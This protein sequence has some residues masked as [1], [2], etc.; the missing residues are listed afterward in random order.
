MDTGT[1]WQFDEFRPPGRDYGR[2][3]EV[4]I[5]DASHRDFRDLESEAA[6]ALDLIGL[7]GTE[8]LLDV[9]C[10]TGVFALAATQRCAAVQAAD[11]S[12]AMLEAA[13]QRA[14][15]ED[16]HNIQFHHAGFLTLALPERSLDVVTTTFAFHHLPDF[17]KGIALDNMARFL[18]PGGKLYMRDVILQSGQVLENIQTFIEHQAR[19]GGDF[20][21]E[22]AEGHFR[23]EYS[24]YDWVMDG[25]FTR[26]GFT[27]RHRSYEGGVIG[28]YV[29]TRD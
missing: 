15:A 19:L 3:E 12:E 8:M 6:G 13:R 23:D 4:A 29:L 25:L 27:I 5:Y 14:T 26:S 2:E 9:G 17:W 18:K 11:V 20:L 1:S 10:G 16:V 22:D 28:T 21:R 24:T 7:N